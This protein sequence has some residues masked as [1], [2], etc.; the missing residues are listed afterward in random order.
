MDKVIERGNQVIKK[1][2]MAAKDDLEY[3]SGSDDEDYEW[4]KGELKVVN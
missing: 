4:V 1:M 2:E 3:I